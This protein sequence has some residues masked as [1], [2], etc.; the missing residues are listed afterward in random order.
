[1]ASI[2]FTIIGKKR[3]VDVDPQTPCFGCFVTT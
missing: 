2:N 1:M 3:T